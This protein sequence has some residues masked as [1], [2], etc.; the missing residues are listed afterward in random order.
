MVLHAQAPAFDIFYTEKLTYKPKQEI[1][2]VWVAEAVTNMVANMVAN[3]FIL[4][5]RHSGRTGTDAVS[6]TFVFYKNHPFGNSRITN[7]HADIYP[8]CNKKAPR[9]SGAIPNFST[10]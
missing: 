9:L 10:S 1:E 4:I 6:S 8:G 3:V 2:P 7:P 5:I